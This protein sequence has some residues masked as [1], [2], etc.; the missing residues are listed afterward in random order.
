M[1][2]AEEREI[3]GLIDSLQELNEPTWGILG[4]VP[5]PRFL[6]I[7]RDEDLGWFWSIDGGDVDEPEALTRLVELGPKAL[8]SLL[9][10]LD[11]PRP[12][13]LV[14][15][16]GALACD[17]FRLG[18]E[19]L[20]PWA[21]ND[22]E[23]RA[24]RAHPTIGAEVDP[25][26]FDALPPVG[27][28][29][30][31]VGDVCFVALGQITSRDY[32]AARCVCRFG[33]VVN[34]PT[35]T[36]ELAR[37]VRAAWSDCNPAAEL[38][39][40]LTDVLWGATAH[41]WPE[42]FAALQRLVTYFPDE[43]M[44]AIATWI[45]ARIDGPVTEPAGGFAT[46]PTAP[47]MLAALRFSDREDVTALLTEAILRNDDP[48]VLAAGMSARLAAEEPELVT[49]L[50]WN[51]LQRG[52]VD[53]GPQNRFP[54]FHHRVVLQRSLEVLPDPAPLLQLALGAESLGLRATAC[55]NL[56]MTERRI[57]QAVDLLLP[58]L[59][60]TTPLDEERLAAPGSAASYPV[61]LCDRAAEAL[62]RHLADERVEFALLGTPAE[63]DACIDGLR[64]QA[65]MRRR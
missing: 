11:D 51:A 28:H 25:F 37:F 10:A 49:A 33:V 64:K 59:D 24:A 6:P 43:S 15:R 20:G 1:G 8:P 54:W 17:D 29:V 32:A 5:V 62:H 18:R 2:A 3:A 13:R 40:R 19:A 60:D 58:L 48:S 56:W 26:R 65:R 12:T 31:T 53:P 9:D 16:P 23:R 39:R 57:P 14:I 30:V 35:A 21:L 46:A 50:A 44:P 36:P 47:Q 34:S 38:Y 45:R 27:A 4:E 63:V 7:P 61:R 42:R 41:P 52:P 22:A 55:A